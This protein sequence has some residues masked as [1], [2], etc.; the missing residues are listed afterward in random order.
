MGWLADMFLTL[1][2]FYMGITRL[3]VLLPFTIY[4]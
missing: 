2:H 4:R 3:T 1:F